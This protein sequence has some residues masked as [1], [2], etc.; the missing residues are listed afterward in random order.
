[1]VRGS[2]CVKVDTAI[3]LL[4]ALQRE[5]ALVFIRASLIHQILRRSPHSGNSGGVQL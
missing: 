5:F 2:L 4:S 1:M 3:D